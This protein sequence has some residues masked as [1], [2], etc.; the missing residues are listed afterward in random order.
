[1]N[2]DRLS[3]AIIGLVKILDA[4]REPNGC[5][6]DKKQTDA[7]IKLYLLEEAY[8]VMDAI[9]TGSPN[10]VCLE[11]GDLLFQ[12]LF[13]ACLASERDE[14]DFVDVL[15]KI[16]AKMIHRHPHVFA[17]VKVDNIEDVTRNWERIKYEER[18]KMNIET[19]VFES[20]PKNLP[21]L[22]RAH[23]LSERI[24]IR[25]P[26]QKDSEHTWAEVQEEFNKLKSTIDDAGKK[27]FPSTMGKLLFKMAILARNMDFNAENLLRTSINDFIKQTKDDCSNEE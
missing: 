23:R 14:F 16:S 20:I 24:A 6:W 12:I 1:M 22:L 19:S 9:E 13:L 27:A 5:P 11:L 10:E 26:E 4:L 21:A 7:S 17:S 3:Q 25:Y 8:E 18:K 15:E 2:H